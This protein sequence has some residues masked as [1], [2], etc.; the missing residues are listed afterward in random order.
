[1]AKKG[2]DES[3][4]FDDKTLV[5]KVMGKMFCLCGLENNPTSVN[6][7]CDPE[8]AIELREAYSGVQPGYHMNKQHWNTVVFD[9]SFDDA[10][11][12]SWIDDSYELVAA[13]LSKK[14]K[15]EL[16]TL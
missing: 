5:F 10:E 15:A 16:N 8:K 4:P 13:S 3:F 11:A 7:K 12:R 1:L 6:L 14:L 2:V 9:G